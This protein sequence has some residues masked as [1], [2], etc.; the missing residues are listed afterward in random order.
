MGAW[1]GP[2]PSTGRSPREGSILLEFALLVLF[3]VVAFG[4]MVAAVIALPF[5]LIGGVLK[6]LVFAIAL[7]FRLI[8]ALF[9]VAAGVTGTLFGGI[10]ALGSVL[11]T[12]LIAVGALLFLPLLPILALFGLIWL[13]GRSAR[14]AQA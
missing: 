3:G 6:L 12:I 11:L 14:K 13:F 8:G 5:L 1:A 4:L 7:P 2:R 9:G 10:A